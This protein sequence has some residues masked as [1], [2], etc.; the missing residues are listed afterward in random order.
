MCA[1]MRL[2]EAKSSPVKISLTLASSASRRSC[3]TAIVNP[4]FSINPKANPRRPEPA[5]A[6]PAICRGRILPV[7]CVFAVKFTIPRHSLFGLLL[8]SPWWVSIML[9]AVLGA[10]LAALM[11]REYVL[12]ALTGTLPL[13]IVGA[14]AAWQQWHA[15]SEEKRSQVLQEAAQLSWEDFSRRLQQSWRLQGI[16]A[17]APEHPGADWRITREGQ[18]TLVL[19]RRWKASVHGLEPLRQLARAMEDSGIGHGLYI[20]AGGELSPPAQ[21]FAREHNIQIWLG[22]ALSLFLLGKRPGV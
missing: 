20:A 18:Y 5:R 15:P 3:C 16:H 19:A 7:R 13:L 14:V 2:G 9:A 8:R 10:A 17:S 11:P 4:L 12:L 21:R 22:D 1:C 6:A